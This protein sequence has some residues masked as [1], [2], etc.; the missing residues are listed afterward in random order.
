M[1]DIGAVRNAFGANDTAIGNIGNHHRIT[2]PTI[3]KGKL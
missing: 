3:P 1:D 2:G